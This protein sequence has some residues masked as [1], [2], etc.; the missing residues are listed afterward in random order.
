MAGDTPEQPIQM[1]SSLPGD[2][3]AAPSPSPSPPPPAQSSSSASTPTLTANP[4]SD[5][6]AQTHILTSVSPVDPSKQRQFEARYYLPS[7]LSSSHSAASRSFLDLPESYFAPTP[8]EL[9]QAYA[10]QVQKTK[11]LVDRPLLTKRLREREEAE[12]SRVK[13]AKWPQTRIRI[14]LADRSQLEGVFPSTDKLVHLYEFVRLALREDVRDTAWYLYQSPP[15]TEYRKGD[16]ALRG[17]NLMDLD[18]TPSSALYIKFEAD[19]L[20]DV[21]SPPPLIPSLLSLAASLPAPPSFDPSRPDPS[22]AEKTPEQLKKEKEEKLKRLMGKGLLGGK[23]TGGGGS[24][25]SVKP[26]WMRG[27]KDAHKK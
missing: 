25:G 8:V 1:L 19:E 12:K 11:D 13:A 20:N 24:L 17:K 3:Q 9:Q 15:R 6:Q 5:G 21:A 7:T 16:P 23:G 14:R 26:A 10:G 18:F 4:G 2:V 27:G 22:T